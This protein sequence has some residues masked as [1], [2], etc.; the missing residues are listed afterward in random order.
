M[1]SLIFGTVDPSGKPPVTFPAGLSQVPAQTTAQ[2]PGTST[3]VDFSE[4]VDIG[5]RW[6]QLRRQEQVVHPNG[7]AVALIA[8]GIGDGPADRG[9]LE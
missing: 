8:A 4:G 2:W 6:Y 9:Y 5:Y 1:G 7:Q 3:G